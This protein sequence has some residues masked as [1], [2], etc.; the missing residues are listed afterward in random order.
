MKTPKA[1]H[2]LRVLL[3]AALELAKPICPLAAQ[4]GQ[5]LELGAINQERL[6]QAATAAG[7]RVRDIRAVIPGAI[8]SRVPFTASP[9]DDKQLATLREKYQ[10]EKV[11]SPAPDEWTAQLL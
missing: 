6:R 7:F 8:R 3:F 1:C 10:L 11:I 4:S 2:C 9:Y 5:T